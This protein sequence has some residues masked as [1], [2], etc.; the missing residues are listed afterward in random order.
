MARTRGKSSF[1]LRSGQN[2]GNRTSFK[3]MGSSPMQKHPSNKD[4]F[5]S[6]NARITQRMNKTEATKGDWDGMFD[7]ATFT[8]QSYGKH[9]DGYKQH[10]YY[11]E[12]YDLDGDGQISGK[13]E[14]KN[15]RNN[16]TGHQTFKEELKQANIDGGNQYPTL[17]DSERKKGFY[18]VQHP[19]TGEY[20]KFNNSGEVMPQGRRQSYSKEAQA[21]MDK[22]SPAFDQPRSE[23]D[24]NMWTDEAQTET[25]PPPVEETP[26]P[27]PVEETPPPVEETPPPPVEETP[28]P[29]QETTPPPVEET[30]PPTTPEPPK[31]QGSFGEEFKAARERGDKEFMFDKDGDGVMEP[32]HTRRADETPEEWE[33][34]FG[35]SREET[36]GIM[37]GPMPEQTGTGTG[38]ESTVD[39]QPTQQETPVTLDAVD[40]VADAQNTQPELP[41]QGQ[42]PMA[43]PPENQAEMTD[44]QLAEKA[45][46]P[47]GSPQSTETA[48]ATDT[49]DTV[50]T[51]DTTEAADEPDVPDT[52]DT[53][54]P[55]EKDDE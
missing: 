52:P 17:T 31:S 9:N 14:L 30:P 29:V 27:P 42:P 55:A 36:P 34:K 53:P 7:P 20:I 50:D 19:K 39:K 10:P 37:S 26:P 13:K 16:P 47:G 24:P 43:P 1:K 21:W 28:P 23:F 40:P 49:V 2:G 15:E 5:E 6:P 4:Y 44:E 32:Y 41:P 8:Q 18:E 3:S 48:D 25:P 33:K 22:T 12:K 11:I 54:E 51:T 38:M 46:G 35:G 45:Y